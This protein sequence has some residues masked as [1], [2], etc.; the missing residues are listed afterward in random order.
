MK[1]F[2]KSDFQ[3]GALAP[4]C[5]TCGARARIRTPD[6]LHWQCKICDHPVDDDG[7][8]KSK[9]RCVPCRGRPKCANCGRMSVGDG[10]TG[11]H[12]ES[13]E[14]SLDDDGNCQ[15]DPCHV[16]NPYSCNTCDSTLE[17]ELDGDD[18]IYCN[19]CDHYVD[20]DGDC[21]SSDRGHCSTCDTY[22]DCPSCGSSTY[23][24]GYEDE[25]GDYIKR[26]SCDENCYHEIDSDGDC[27]TDSC[28]ACYPIECSS[29]DSSIYDESDSEG[30]VWCSEC[31]CY[32]D[33]DGDRLSG[34][35]TCNT[36][37]EDIEGR[38][39]SDGEIQCETCNHYID[40]RQ[41]CH[42]RL[43]NL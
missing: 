4:V 5:K 25:D 8:C 1:D 35:Y 13:C 42:I 29:C 40:S 39:D 6:N 33:E 38:L 23:E 3:K 14:H 7:K 22:P 11:F 27:R 20:E 2:D 9:H 21:V 24:N 12:C 18:E 15:D 34:T 36:C 17:G 43:L 41:L 37:N 32:V 28:N 31:E 30:H 16:C 10:K 26:Y 19:E